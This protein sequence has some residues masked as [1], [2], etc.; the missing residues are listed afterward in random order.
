MAIAVLMTRHPGFGKL[1]FTIVVS[2]H[3]T[4]T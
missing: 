2:L 1:F 3:Q 4:D